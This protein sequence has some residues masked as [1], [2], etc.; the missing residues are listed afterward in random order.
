MKLLTDMTQPKKDFKKVYSE[1][2]AF[3]F[4]N[5]VGRGKKKARRELWEGQ[6]GK[7]SKSTSGVETDLIQLTFSF[8][9]I[10]EIP[11]QNLCEG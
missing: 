10:F 8:S 6:I 11:V 1:H 2:R 7:L 9:F 5:R 4:A 3:F